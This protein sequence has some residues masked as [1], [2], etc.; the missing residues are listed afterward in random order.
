VKKLPTFEPLSSAKKPSTRQLRTGLR[1]TWEHHTSI[2]RL[3]TSPH[4]LHCVH[5]CA[6]RLLLPNCENGRSKTSLFMQRE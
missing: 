2:T 1:V 5:P 6:R 4:A 3:L